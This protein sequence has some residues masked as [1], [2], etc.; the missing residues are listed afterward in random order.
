MRAKL[1]PEQKIKA[2]ALRRAGHTFT[3]I[4]EVFNVGKDAIRRA[5]DPEWARRRCEQINRS[6]SA[7]PRIRDRSKDRPRVRDRSK[8]ARGPK[9][10]L[11]TEAEIRRLIPEDTRDLTGRIFGDPLPGR[12]A[13]DRAMHQ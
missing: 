2:I 8:E 12:S 9:G 13:L 7:N 1:T 3:E 10:P 6:R 11:P 4:G 5:T